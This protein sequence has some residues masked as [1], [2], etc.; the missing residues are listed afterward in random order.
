MK[1]SK[2]RKSL[3]P[4]H[5]RIFE[6]SRKLSFFFASFRLP[7]AHDSKL[8]KRFLKRKKALVSDD[9]VSMRC[10]LEGQ[11]RSDEGK[12]KFLKTPNDPRRDK[13]I[14]VENGKKTKKKK[15][16]NNIFNIIS[17]CSSKCTRRKLVELLLSE[18][19]ACYY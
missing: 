18:S 8:Y 10:K 13:T 5:S 9:I 14:N 1:A 16:F 15:K 3:S 7:S 2:E 11:K 12:K 6:S 4:E 17:G 19:S